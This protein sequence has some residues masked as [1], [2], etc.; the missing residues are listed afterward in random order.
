LHKRSFVF[1]SEFYFSQKSHL[2][3]TKMVLLNVKRGESMHF[4]YETTVAEDIGKL[5][6]D[7]VAIYNGCLKIQRVCAG[8]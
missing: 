8:L 3:N 7:I 4:L 5:T 1:R 2:K 6:R